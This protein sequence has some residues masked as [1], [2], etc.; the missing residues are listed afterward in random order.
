MKSLL[1]FCIALVFGAASAPAHAGFVVSGSDIR[2]GQPV[3]VEPGALGTV[4]V[5]VSAA[6]PCSNSH[7]PELRALA[8]EFPQFHFVAV[9]AN[10]DEAREEATTY[11]AKADMPFPVVRDRGA[12][13]ADE[14]RALK[15]PHAYVKLVDGSLA[16]RGGVTDSKD[17]HRSQRKFLREALADLV[18]GRP[19]AKPEGRTLGCVIARKG[20]Y[21][22]W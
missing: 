12:K 4:V 15:T 2:S 22:D 20:K 5:F 19:V 11:F 18:A 7:V 14:F 9:H 8:K 17:L 3:Q 21:A 13:L 10:A 1:L 6:C 16:Y